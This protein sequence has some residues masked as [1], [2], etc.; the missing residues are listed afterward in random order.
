MIARLLGG[1][2]EWAIPSD[3]STEAVGGIGSLSSNEVLR[4]VRGGPQF[5][6]R[7]MLTSMGK[8]ELSLLELRSL[9]IRRNLMQTSTSSKG[10]FDVDGRR[11][12]FS[13]LGF[14][15]RLHPKLS[16]SPI[17]IPKG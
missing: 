17:P 15:K 12:R 9:R 8:G 10:R 4:E 7:F 5:Q 2:L 6:L 3:E 13:P 1:M 14:W 11:T 16:G